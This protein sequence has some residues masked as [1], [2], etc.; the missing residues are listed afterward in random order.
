NRDGGDRRLE[1]ALGNLLRVGV[2][3]A[4]ALVFVGGVIYLIRHGHEPAE[5]HLFQGEPAEF[6]HP[7]A[8]VQAFPQMPGRSLILLG[9]LVLI[10]T[11][12]VRVAFSAVGFVWERDYAYVWM[13]LTVLALLLFS[14]FVGHS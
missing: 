14:L 12:V 11:P 10:A 9:L 3:T 6:R 4:A 2:F 7:L 8:V 13:T 5:Y 1:Q